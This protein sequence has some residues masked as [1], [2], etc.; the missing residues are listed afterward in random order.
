[1]TFPITQPLQP[2]QEVV[3]IMDRKW[4]QA[5]LPEILQDHQHN[6]IVIME[7]FRDFSFS[8][9]FHRYMFYWYLKAERSLKKFIK[10]DSG[11]SRIKSRFKN[12]GYLLKPNEEFQRIQRENSTRVLFVLSLTG[13][14]LDFF[15]QSRNMYRSYSL[16][17]SA[18]HS[19]GLVEFWIFVLIF[20]CRKQQQIFDFQIVLHP[21]QWAAKD[22]SQLSTWADNYHSR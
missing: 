3:P 15:S 19:F 8:F 13:F 21:N 14:I 2:E 6:G 20:S 10:K 16:M 18:S 4:P 22:I 9:F 1:M 12:H 7:W 5:R 17:S 11:V